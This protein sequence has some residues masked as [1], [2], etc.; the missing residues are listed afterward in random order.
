[1]KYVFNR[2]YEGIIYGNCISKEVSIKKGE[3]FDIDYCSDNYF[4]EVG[5]LE[6]HQGLFMLPKKYFTEYNR[7]TTLQ[8]DLKIKSIIK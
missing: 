3:I 1:M 8:R 7:W 2:N 4:V 5:N 6:N